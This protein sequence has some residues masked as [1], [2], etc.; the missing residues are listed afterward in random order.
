MVP[1]RTLLKTSPKRHCVRPDGWARGMRARHGLAFFL[2]NANDHIRAEIPNLTWM[3]GI[4][5]SQHRIPVQLC[6]ALL[7]Q[8]DN[9]IPARAT[10]GRN[11]DGAGTQSRWPVRF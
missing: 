3:E 8:P 5:M 2:T 7:F 1:N 9:W 6:L 11:D 10:L 4:V